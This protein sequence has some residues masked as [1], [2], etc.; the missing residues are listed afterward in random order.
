MDQSELRARLLNLRSQ[1]GLGNDQ[2]ADCGQSDPDWIS[3][4]IGAFICV[5]CCGT[6]RH[7]GTHVSRIKSIKL[8][9]WT[10]QFVEKVELAGGNSAV[11]DEFLCN[12]PPYWKRPQVGVNDPA[13]V[14]EEFIINKYK[15]RLFHTSSPRP[16]MVPVKGGFLWKKSSKDQDSNSKWTQKFFM[17]SGSRLVCYKSPDNIQKPIGEFSLYDA[18]IYLADKLCGRKFSIHLVAGINTQELQ[19]SG[20]DNI[21]AESWFLS[22]DSGQL[23][24]EWLNLF[25][26]ARFKDFAA[27]STPLYQ[28]ICFDY[29]H[30]G[31]LIKLNALISMSEDNTGNNSHASSTDKWYNYKSSKKVKWESYYASLDKNHILFKKTYLS[32]YS[33][34]IIEF[35]SDCRLEAVPLDRWI[36]DTQESVDSSNS[37]GSDLQQLSPYGVSQDLLQ[38]LRKQKQQANSFVLNIS[39]NSIT[40]AD[41]GLSKP[42][43]QIFTQLTLILACESSSDQS[44]W[45]QAINQL[46]PLEKEDIE[47]DR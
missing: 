21:P 29:Q 11:N 46:K 35:S 36:V 27:L 7:L 5:N 31:P 20:S 33:Q 34:A 42:S 16:E 1:P 32:H 41:Y 39:G 6:H 22:A 17:L 9:D 38:Q 12:L 26:L 43:K 14:R 40:F 15:R 10:D 25:R 30:Q 13:Y 18:K 28:Q 37:E 47:L 24:L 44:G 19:Q 45:M 3:V 2:C 8:D 23:V 4:N